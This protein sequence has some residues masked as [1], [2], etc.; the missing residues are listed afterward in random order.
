M[1][2]TPDWIWGVDIA[3]CRFDLAFVHRDGQYQTNAVACD[4][5]RPAQRLA[6]LFHSTRT[7]AKL[8]AQPFPPLIVYVER[9]TG[10]HPNP[11][12][13]HAAGVAQ[14]AIYDGLSDVFRFPVDVLLVPTS[15]WK[16]AVLGHGNATKEAIYAWAA[17]HGYRGVQDGADALGVAAFAAQECNFGTGP[18]HPIIHTEE[19][20]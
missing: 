2:P 11:A 17:A 6:Q 18:L 14:A 19:A 7:F 3:A 10:A 5:S 16:K 13:D 20:A 9:P 1:S 15:T 8:M 4:E 12:L